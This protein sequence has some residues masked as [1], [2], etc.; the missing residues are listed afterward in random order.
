[1]MTEAK[2]KI[3]NLKDGESHVIVGANDAGAEVWR[4]NDYLFLF[5]IPIYGGSP[6]YH[7]VY[8]LNQVADLLKE[9]ES[10]T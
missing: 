5:E 3:L 10:W 7:A 8:S 6:K 2:N 4:K 1:M 9:Y